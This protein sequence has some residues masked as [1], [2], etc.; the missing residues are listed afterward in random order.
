[1][2]GLTF[3]TAKEEPVPAQASTTMDPRQLVAPGAQ[4]NNTDFAFTQPWPVTT[5][6]VTTMPNL[7]TNTTDYSTMPSYYNYAEN[8]SPYLPPATGVNAQY[9]ASFGNF[10]AIPQSQVPLIQPVMGSNGVRKIPRKRERKDGVLYL[11]PTDV[12]RE[13]RDPPK[14]WGPKVSGDNQL[15]SQDDHLFSY[16][17]DGELGAGWPAAQCKKRYPRLEHSTRCRFE[18]CDDAPLR[19][20]V[21]GQPWVIFDERQNLDGSVVDP[22]HNAGYVH[23]NCLEKHFDILELWKPCDIR[24]DNRHF[25][26]ESYPYFALARDDFLVGIEKAFLEWYEAERAKYWAAKEKGV[27]RSREREFRLDQVFVDY[28]LANEPIGRTKQRESRAGI[29]IGTHRGDR[30]RKY[31]L[32]ELRDHDL[33]DENRKPVPNADARLEQMK[34]EKVK[35]R[36]KK[37]L[38]KRREESENEAAGQNATADTNVTTHS[39]T[40][41]VVVDLTEDHNVATPPQQAEPVESNASTSHEVHTQ[42]EPVTYTAPVNHTSY[43]QQ[44]PVGYS[45]NVNPLVSSQPAPVDYTGHVSHAPFSQQ[46]PIGHNGIAG[47]AIYSQHQ[48]GPSEDLHTNPARG[49]NPAAPAPAYSVYG[50]GAA[51]YQPQP[52]NYQSQQPFIDFVLNELVP[53]DF[54][55]QQA[56]NVA[57][58]APPSR[59]RGRDE[60]VDDTAAVE[61]STAKRQRQEPPAPK[62]TDFGYEDVRIPDRADNESLNRWQAGYHTSESI[63]QPV[64]DSQT[65]AFEVSASIDGGEADSPDFTAHE[66]IREELSKA[67]MLSLEMDNDF[68]QFD[69]WVGNAFNGT[70]GDDLSGDA[71]VNTGGGEY[72]PQPAAPSPTERFIPPSRSSSGSAGLSESRWAA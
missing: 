43:Y 59:K 28:K 64:A 25:I 48:Q 53:D 18:D 15:D 3:P 36:R 32:K 20:I 35:N 9:P 5:M 17:S 71:Y 67:D 19:S 21:Q 34:A 10:N 42:Q 60:P 72:E 50:V 37:K 38:T 63:L 39:G 22:F 4:V 8:R 44:D 14:S 1:M 26:R 16:T 61:E 46:G 24:L 33:L 27:R 65:G 11:E 52:I 29:D 45:G 41:G 12:Y 70:S 31:Y 49:Y 54:H 55:D 66:W 40:E 23:L 56:R 2:S 47:H 57:A 6:P 51:L 7:L 68:S 30:E 58:A 69:G 13:P 62:V